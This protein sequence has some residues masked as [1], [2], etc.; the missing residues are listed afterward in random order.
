MKHEH[1]NTKLLYSMQTILHD[2]KYFSFTINT[3]M[4]NVSNKAHN[5]T[6]SNLT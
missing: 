5:I 2:Q 6:H 1:N 3:A 4:H